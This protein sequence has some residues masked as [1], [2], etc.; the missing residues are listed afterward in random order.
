M[1]TALTCFGHS[2]KIETQDC[3]VSTFLWNLVCSKATKY[4]F[5]KE[6][7]NFKGSSKIIQ[8]WMIILFDGDYDLFSLQ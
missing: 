1:N 3:N 8:R 7:F 6:L 5:V 2:D 4:D